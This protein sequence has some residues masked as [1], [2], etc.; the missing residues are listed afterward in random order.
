MSV[1]NYFRKIFTGYQS[2]IRTIRG[3]E[4]HY[5]FSVKAILFDPVEMLS[6]LKFKISG[7]EISALKLFPSI[8]NF[9]E[10]LLNSSKQQNETVIASFKLESRK[11]KVIRSI[12]TIDNMPC[13]RYDFFLDGNLIS[14]FQRQYDYGKG[15]A[16]SLQKMESYGSKPQTQNN[17]SYYWTNTDTNQSVFFE[18]FGHT[19]LWLIYDSIGLEEVWKNL[20]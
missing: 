18:K 3:V 6:D 2:K 1:F 19:H 17:P 7:S 8:E 5:K 16:I 12:K 15:I 14:V 9:E 20:P 13:S 10:R 4:I 11:I